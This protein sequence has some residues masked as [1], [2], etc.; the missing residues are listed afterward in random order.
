MLGQRPPS[1][2]GGS[3]CTGMK[4]GRPWRD[5]G[6]LE[7]EPRRGAPSGVE[8]T[9]AGGGQGQEP[10]LQSEPRAAPGGPDH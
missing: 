8:R 10:G 2:R 6:A 1:G 7:E 5:L 4:E 3:S 9:V